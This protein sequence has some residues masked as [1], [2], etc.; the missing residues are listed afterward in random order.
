[1]PLLQLNAYGSDFTLHAGHEPP[2]PT[3]E[4][5][6][7]GSGP[8]IIMVHG[9]KFSPGHPVA[10]PHRH[11]L[12]LAPERRCRKA[13]SWPRGLGFGTPDPSEGLAIA[14]GW[15][16]RG[17]IWTA[18]RQAELAGDAL[19][20]L[21]TIIH[22]IA[23][24]RPIHAIAHSLGARVVLSA[25]PVLQPGLL[26][27]AILLA[28][29]EY[30]SRASA[31]MA[32]A[33]GQR[34]EVINITSRE[35]DLFDVMLEMLIAPSRRGDRALGLHMPDRPN[36]VTLQLDHADTLNALSR[37][38]FPVAPPTSTICHWSSY[39]RAGVFALYAAALRGDS[40]LDMVELR[41]LAA[42]PPQPRWA[43][44]RPLPSVGLPALSGRP[45]AR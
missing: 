4:R 5:A 26:R 1:M 38:G 2:R 35:N 12:S 10:C 14:F 22:A 42:Q 21:I 37:I 13:A 27:R 31:A 25:L 11:I 19:A 7:D 8:V 6:L 41:R 45:V 18:Y 43:R 16:A 3:L 17:A 20:Q 23:P 33:G 30:E 15:Q 40:R 36:T 29:A 32:S 34:T 28:G 39:L 44:V 24:E 9:F